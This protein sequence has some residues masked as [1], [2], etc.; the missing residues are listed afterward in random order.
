MNNVFVNAPVY[1]N[2]GLA[3]FIY[4]VY[5]IT[6]LRASVHRWVKHTV[7]AWKR[8][9]LK[10]AVSAFCSL[11][12]ETEIGG[13]PKIQQVQL[14]SFGS[15]SSSLRG[16]WYSAR[17]AVLSALA[18]CGSG[19]ASTAQ[20]F[21]HDRSNTTSPTST[22]GQILLSD[23]DGWG[24]LGCYLLGCISVKQAILIIWNGGE[25]KILPSVYLQLVVCLSVCVFTSW[26]PSGFAISDQQ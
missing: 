25:W 4:E 15:Y 14:S 2:D 21:H 3:L 12:R 7:L 16:V 19:S 22:E 1:I 18:A 5:P 11:W 10:P 26:A 13:K 23:S 8:Q 17:E 20:W 24:S 9:S 6:H